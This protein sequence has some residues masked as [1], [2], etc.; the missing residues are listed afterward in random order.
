[1]TRRRLLPTGRIYTAVFVPVTKFLEHVEWLWLSSH[2]ARDSY[3]SLQIKCYLQQGWRG[4]SASRLHFLLGLQGGSSGYWQVLP[5]EVEPSCLC[6]LG[7]TDTT[8]RGFQKSSFPN[9]PKVV[10]SEGCHFSAFTYGPPQ[11]SID[12]QRP[13]DNLQE[14]LLLVVQL[15]Q[16]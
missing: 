14:P 15:R 2:V 10:A 16:K 7:T 3:A 6:H 8:S 12:Y 5:S 9:K 1:M 11:N 4:F 13:L